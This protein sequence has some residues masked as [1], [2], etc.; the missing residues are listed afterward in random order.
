MV[1]LNLHTRQMNPNLEVVLLQDSISY[2]TWH[3]LLVIKKRYLNRSK[4]VLLQFFIYCPITIIA[5]IIH[6]VKILML[7]NVEGAETGSWAKIYIQC[8]IEFL[9][10][11][12]I[13]ELSGPKFK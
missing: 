3:R 8:C 12:S 6:V 1:D 13:G 10:V 2:L 9:P 4:T 7:L 11:Q 5:L